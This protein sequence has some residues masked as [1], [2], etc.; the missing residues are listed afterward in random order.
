MKQ[1]LKV[2]V[3]AIF[4]TFTFNS[5]ANAQFGL[6]KGVAGAVTSGK[7]KG[8]EVKLA[9]GKSVSTKRAPIGKT[10]VMS[11]I[12]MDD[13]EATLNVFKAMVKKQNKYNNDT[14]ARMK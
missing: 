3:L 13:D 1:T 9:N 12:G 8:K 6:I 7:S 11:W 14:D 2:F 5:V 4:A 10:E